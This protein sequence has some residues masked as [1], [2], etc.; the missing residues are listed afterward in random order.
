MEVA[1]FLRGRPCRPTGSGAVFQDLHRA[2][3][4]HA[5]RWSCPP[6]SAVIGYR[7][8][9]GDPAIL[10]AGDHRLWRLGYRPACPLGSSQSLRCTTPSFAR[11]SR[12]RSERHIFAVGV[13]LVVQLLGYYAAFLITPYDLTWHLSYSTERLVLQIFPLLL[14]LILCASLPVEAVLGAQHGAV[15]W[16]PP[17]Y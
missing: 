6:G 14:F 9:R 10:L 3:G 15:Q 1:H 16:S 4:R 11:R 5:W 12:R 8:S 17:C 13:I 7:P 2:A